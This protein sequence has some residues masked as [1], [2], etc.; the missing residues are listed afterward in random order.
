MEIHAEN[1]RFYPLTMEKWSDFESLFGPRG[2]SGGCWCMYWRVPRREF[3]KGQGEPFRQAMRGLVEAGTVPG[4][5]AYDGRDAVGWISIGKREEF[6]LL[7][8][9]RV[10]APVDD[11]PVWSIVCFYIAKAYREK[12]LMLPLINAAVEYA[13]EHR[14]KIVEAYPMDPYKHL[15]EMSAYYGIT[16]VFENAGFVEAAR[17][18]EHHPVMRKVL[19][20]S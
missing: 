11:E 2:A 17:R 18:S 6:I 13:A 12:G 4:L 9:S 10:L 19:K 7:K 1:Y 20:T 5:L 14:A 16:P 8:Q 15:S 3:T